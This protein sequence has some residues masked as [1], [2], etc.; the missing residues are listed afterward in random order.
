MPTIRYANFLIIIEHTMNFL[1]NFGTKTMATAPL[2]NRVRNQN[3][4][5][6]DGNPSSGGPRRELV[7]HDLS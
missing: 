2:I 4:A 1:Y 3:S 7:R 5:R 6:T